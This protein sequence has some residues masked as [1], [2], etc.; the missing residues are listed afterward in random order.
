[1]KIRIGHRRF[2]SKTAAV[3]AI[4]DVL[5]RY[6]IGTTITGPDAEL[7]TDLLAQHHERDLKIGCGVRSFEVEQNLGTRGFW[8]TRHDGTRTDWSYLTCL[9]PPTHLENVYAALRTEVRGQIQRFKFNAFS[10]GP[11]LC[12]VSGEFV[13]L[14][15]A[16]VDHNPP[17]VDLVARWLT[18]LG[19]SVHDLQVEATTDGATDT[20]LADRARAVEWATYHQATAGLRIVTPAVNL[21]LLRI[22]NV[23]ENR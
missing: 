10:N 22:R 21:S 15:H 2:S 7:L 20:R 18:S 14:E 8:L 9:K 6:S 5:Y 11:V 16:H 13:T 17:F 3:Q 1:M 19:L 4:R 23:T 12:A